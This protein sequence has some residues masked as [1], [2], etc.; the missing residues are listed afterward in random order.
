MRFLIY[1]IDKCLEQG[2]PTVAKVAGGVTGGVIGCV[3][4]ASAGLA[5]GGLLCATACPPIALLAV[6]VLPI[7]SGTHVG[8]LRGYK[9]PSRCVLGLFGLIG[10]F[11]RW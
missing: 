4:G 10:R 11:H 3:T 6:L 9:K 1:T 7:V 8:A 2:K 5:L